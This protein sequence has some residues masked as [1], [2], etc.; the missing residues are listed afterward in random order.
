MNPN[1]DQT[2]GNP[3]VYSKEMTRE[4]KRSEQWH[5]GALIGLAITIVGYLLTS[6]ISAPRFLEITFVVAA[7]VFAMAYMGT[8]IWVY[9]LRTERKRSAK[10]GQDEGETNP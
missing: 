6:F 8:T 4:A 5:R 2:P 7:F 10:R 1:P 9:S 3:P